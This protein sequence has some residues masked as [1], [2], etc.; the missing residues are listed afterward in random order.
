MLRKIPFSI[1]VLALTLAALAASASPAAAA[2]GKPTVVIEQ[3]DDTNVHEEPDG[4]ITESRTTGTRRTAT[5]ADG[6]IAVDEELTNYQLTTLKGELVLESWND[7]TSSYVL[8]GESTRFY[9]LEAHTD[10]VRGDGSE[11]T[12]DSRMLVVNDRVVIWEFPAPVC[13]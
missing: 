1:I 5:Y 8:E 2:D 9:S 11:C 6:R 4:T 13:S 12:I 7:S 10:M 3:I